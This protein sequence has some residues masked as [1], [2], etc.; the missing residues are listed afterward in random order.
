MQQTV[1]PADYYLTNFR[2]L[3]DFVVSH[4]AHLLG[5]ESLDFYHSLIAQPLDAQKLYVRMLL[6]KGRYFR[7]SKLSYDEITSIELAL[8]ALETAGFVIVNAPDADVTLRKLFTKAELID[9]FA[10]PVL[11][12]LGRAALDEVLRNRTATELRDQLLA[13]VQRQPNEQLIQL[14]R[15]AHFL[16]FRLLFFGNLHQDM[17]DFV[18]RDLG[19][20]HYESYPLDA[21]H[22]ALQTRDQVQSHLLYYQYCEQAEALDSGSAEDVVEFLHS[23]IDALF[24]AAESDS[25]LRRRVHRLLLKYARQLERLGATVEALAVY[26]KTDRP[27]S[28]ERQ[29]RLLAEQARFSEAMLLGEQILS[30]STNEEEREFAQGFVPRLLKRAAKQGDDVASIMTST[31]LEPL[32]L[33]T[34]KYKPPTETLGLPVTD[35]SVE[36]S[37]A[38]YF[39]PKGA[40]Y[41][42]ENTLIN[43]IFGLA[44]WDVV[45]APVKGAF[46]HPFQVG[47]A[48]LY[49]DF[50][51]NRQAQLQQFWQSNNHIDALS[52]NVWATFRLKHGIANP[53]VH[54]PSLDEQRLTLALARIPYAHWQVIFERILLDIRHHRSGF[55]DLIW[56]P[57]A[58]GYELI[59][60]K[61]PNDKIQQNQRRW[62]AYFHRHNI[63][64]RLVNVQWQ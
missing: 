41:F 28:R 3:T 61:A 49:E 24:V 16:L 30:T 19:L 29:V 44:L 34:A 18:L 51:H 32:T 1:L 57:D 50:A 42:V 35:L 4:Y 33:Q 64:H 25:V 52:D 55:P 56:F 22:A 11:K 10:D 45:F 23:L 26:Q 38:N 63:P 43:A 36:E 40:C 27:P 31:A 12:S 39:S 47:P 58:G 6:R 59:E 14:C 17:T 5:N 13:F 9:C 20:T 62:M 60:V 2:Q 7:R 8:R 37:V 54:W 53:F 15:D 48:D 21:V 46:Y